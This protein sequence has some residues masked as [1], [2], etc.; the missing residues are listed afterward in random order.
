ALHETLGSYLRGRLPEAMIPSVFVLLDRLPLTP[1]GKVD[2]KALPAPDLAAGT[3]ALHEEPRTATERRLAALWSELLGIPE[4]GVESH[5]FNLGGHSL[6]AM[7]MV[8]RV[9]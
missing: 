6:L 1:N 3:G 5:F 7:R 8:S 9:R 4:I 2:R